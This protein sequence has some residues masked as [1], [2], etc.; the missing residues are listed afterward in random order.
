GGCLGGLGGESAPA[1]R[2]YA[3]SG[4]GAPAA[5]GRGRGALSIAVEELHADAPY[6]QRRIVYRASRYRV[7]YYDD[8]NWVAA[9]GVMVADSLRRA[10]QSSGRF[11]MVLSEPA[12]D[13]AAI[14]GGRV[15]AFDE[16]DEGARRVAHLAVELELR[17][18]ESGRMRWSRRVEERVAMTAPSRDALA[19][20]LSRAV[21]QLAAATAAEI[22]AAA[23]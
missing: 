8:D 12:A 17:D 10:Y 11:A 23:H 9:P 13:T 21:A 19:A 2:T 4:A 1:V 16:V 22:A 14:L 6:D 20:A 3:L 15:V 18:A 7:D 5:S